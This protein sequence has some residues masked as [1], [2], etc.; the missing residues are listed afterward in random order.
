M[1]V[2]H[3]FGR[4]PVEHRQRVAGWDAALRRGMANIG[5]QVERAANR[6]LSGGGAPGAYPVPRRTG[7]LARS[8]GSQV[9]RRHVVVF[10]DAEYA[11]AVHD[12][13]RA[14][15]NPAAPHYPGRP[16]LS[17]AANQVDALGLLLAELEPVL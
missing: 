11:G 3:D 14:Y 1:S 2:R 17:D 13:F 10:N 16:F 12:G 4:L 7:N 15:G 6:N 5:A 8:L 9:G